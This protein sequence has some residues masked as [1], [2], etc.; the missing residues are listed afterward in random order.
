MLDDA[1]HEQSEIARTIGV[2]RST[3]SRKL[4]R[5]VANNN[6]EPNT[7]CANTARQLTNRC[8]RAKPQHRSVAEIT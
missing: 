3:I 7:Y 2:C 8:H 6:G 1:G 4:N 5:N